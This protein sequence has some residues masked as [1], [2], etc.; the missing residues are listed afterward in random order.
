VSVETLT[1][2]VPVLA[3]IGCI[4]SCAI[5]YRH[6]AAEPPTIDDPCPP[7]RTL[8]DDAFCVP[9]SDPNV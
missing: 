6:H 2:A 4:V 8:A 5:R 3:A 1:I 7:V 9:D